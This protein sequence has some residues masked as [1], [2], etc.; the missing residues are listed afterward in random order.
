MARKFDYSRAKDIA[1]DLIERF[2][3][4]LTYSRDTGETYDPSSGTVTSTTES[5]TADTVWLDYSKEEV[6]ET[7]VLRGDARLLVAGTVKVDDRVSFKGSDW[8]IVDVNPLEPGGVELYTEAQA[9][10]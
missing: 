5:Y 9:R 10:R 1:Y 7:I 6:D 4:K 8:R 3:T 2:G